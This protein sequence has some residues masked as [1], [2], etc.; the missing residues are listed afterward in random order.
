MLK[1]R[2]QTSNP[3]LEQHKELPCTYASSPWAKA[4]SP[5]TNAVM[6]HGNATKRKILLTLPRAV[7]SPLCDLI[8]W[9]RLDCPKR[10]T[11]HQT[12]QK[13]AVRPPQETGPAPNFSKTAQT[14]LNTFQM[15][16]CAQMMHKL[17]PLVDNA[18]IK[19]KC[20][21]F[22]HIASEI[23]KIH[24]KMLHMSKWVN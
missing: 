9:G 18:W 3:K 6:Q 13:L 16:P 22:Q 8:A 20:E 7:R 17:L 12:F 23:Y 24:H 5:W 10:P 2:A 19:A 1:Q 4:H 21:K 14:T 15:L 11:L